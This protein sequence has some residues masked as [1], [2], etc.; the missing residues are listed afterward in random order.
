V[1]T[2]F[3]GGSARILEIDHPRNTIRFMPGG[4]AD[5]GWACWWALRVD[6]VEP[7]QRLTL[8][9]NASDEPARNTGQ[10]TGEPLD[11]SWAMAD[12]ASLS[13]DG[14]SW[15]HSA[16]G[17]RNGNRM[18]YQV[19]AEGSS[20]WV[21][22]GP[23]FTPTTTRDLLSAARDKLPGAS[24]FEL[25]KSRE[26]RSVLGLHVRAGE[27]AGE[28]PA[29]WIQARQHAWESGS[30]WVARGLVEWLTAQSEPARWLVA[31]AE[32]IV[33]PIMDVDNVST[34]DGGK[35]ANPRDHNRDW[36]DAPVYSAV[37]EAQKRLLEWTAQG[38]L[39]VFID[40][41]NPAPRD[42]RPFFYCGP[43][44]L[45]TDLG[46]ENQALFLT[47]AQQH[48]NG[49]LPVDPQPRITGPSYHPLWR[50]ISGQWVSEHGNPHTLAVCL[51][52]SWNTPNS[53]T[54]N[55]RT[56]GSQ[57]GESV[58]QYLQRRKK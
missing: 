7:G 45:L 27:L 1:T 28:R 56:V 33:I 8:E 53:T 51:E 16:P 49:P 36:D 52:T 2:D 47:V 23:L 41:H 35:E 43:P 31:N 14:Q 17:R 13:T 32:I 44:E 55:Y 5:R 12:R 54:E 38:R 25:A 39:D 40:L 18:T 57:L 37:A 11:A 50:K 30:S 48:I 6:D 46:R 26:G 58:V 3:E 24:Q 20:L 29:I 42:A 9:L 22:W 10:P 34:G 4:Q 21:A 19:V 15:K